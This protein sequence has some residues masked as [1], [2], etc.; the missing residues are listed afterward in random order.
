MT[1]TERRAEE[2]RRHKAEKKSQRTAN[3]RTGKLST[4][5][6]TTV[7][8]STGRAWLAA[9]AIAAYTLGAAGRQALAVEPIANGQDAGAP[10]AT[11]PLKRFDI[12]AGPLDAALAA[13]EETTGLRVRIDLPRGTV[14]GFQTKGVKG[15][16]RPQDAL[17]L[18]LEAPGLQSA[19]LTGATASDPEIAAVGLRRNDTINVTS[20]MP[21]SVAMTKFTQP[22]LDTPQTV[23][24]VP[25]FVLHDQQTTTLRDT[26]RNVPGISMAAGEF[27]AQGDNLTI[28][29]F[30]ARND[31]FLDG[32]RDF[33]SY[34]R[35]SFDYEQVEVLE[36]P[37][38]VQFGRG[39]TGGV[40][41]QES[42]VSAAQPFVNVQAQFGTDL[43]RRVQADINE[44]LPDLAEGAAFR[45]N[46]VATEGGVAGRPFAANRHYGIAPSLSFGMN[47]PTRETIS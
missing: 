44:P 42:K 12:A 20:A 45:M 46:A 37:S 38:G 9:G 26:L 3:Q 19:I 7:N 16:Y 24:A 15:L 5:N 2:R 32:I 1:R 41:N 13:Y 31:I 43:T 47:T 27:G 40:I 29:G 35:D 6:L 18:L 33:G 30:T 8:L 25:Q 21:D 17:V 23:L 28:R 10:A 36:G 39:S 11:L 4:V 14:A 22:L 34:Y